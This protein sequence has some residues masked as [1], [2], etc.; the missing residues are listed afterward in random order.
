V[1]I[2]T[3]FHQQAVNLPA[4]VEK[5]EICAKIRCLEYAIGLME[6][7]ELGHG[8]GRSHG[9]DGKNTEALNNREE[10][11]N[12]AVKASDSGE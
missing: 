8:H 4:G 2:I 10:F 5:L 12:P 11:A 7:P 3:T 1:A 6:G 9:N